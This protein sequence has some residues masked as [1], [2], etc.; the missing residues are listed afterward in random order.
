MHQDTSSVEQRIEQCWYDL[1]VMEQQGASSDTLEYLYQRYLQL[2]EEKNRCPDGQKQEARSSAVDYPLQRVHYSSYSVA[3][4][5]VNTSRDKSS[6]Q[7]RKA[8]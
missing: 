3:H 5:S 2:V 1:I 4:Q 7:Q 6:Q 8:S